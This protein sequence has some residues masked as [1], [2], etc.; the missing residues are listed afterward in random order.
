MFLSWVD[1]RAEAAV[2]NATDASREPGGECARLCNGQ[3]ARTAGSLCCDGLYLP[4]LLFRNVVEFVQGRT[5]SYQIRLQPGGTV[6]W[7]SEVRGVFYTTA[8]FVSFPFDS[9]SLDLIMTL[10]NNNTAGE[11]WRGVG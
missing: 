7:R 8:S 11:L 6:I 10:Q 1:P 2:R 5:Q 4:T 3:K 9:Q